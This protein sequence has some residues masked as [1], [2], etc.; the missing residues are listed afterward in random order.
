[1]KLL[2]ALVQVTNSDR[3]AFESDKTDF[4]I[5]K[6]AQINPDIELSQLGEEG[7]YGAAFDL[8]DGRA[9]K[10]TS[11][12]QEAL[13]SSA[14]T[15][16]E[17][18]NIAK[19]YKVAKLSNVSGTKRQLRYKFDIYLVLQKKYLPLNYD[20]AKIINMLP[21]DF[22]ANA[23][24]KAGNQFFIRQKK[25]KD[26][27]RAEQF[28]ERFHRLFELQA[29]GIRLEKYIDVA[30]RLIDGL[31]FLSQHQIQ[32]ADIHAQN[33]MKDTQGNLVMIDFGAG[34]KTAAVGK[35]IDIL[36]RFIRKVTRR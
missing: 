30:M 2:D 29:K 20:E 25:A 3:G 34:S 4:K 21:A 19:I 10:I 33:V 26:Y 13:T 11:D 31:Y 12:K 15:K 36:E 28:L 1:M 6:W 32:Y 5:A 17:H 23:I 24:V 8:L 14:L 18:K 9:L 35:D 22:E 16:L 7:T 27:P